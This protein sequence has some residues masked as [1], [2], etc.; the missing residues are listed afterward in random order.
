MC[1][2]IALFLAYHICA[3][4]YLHARHLKI[5]SKEVDGFIYPLL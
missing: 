2:L 5:L 3:D 1:F 4:I